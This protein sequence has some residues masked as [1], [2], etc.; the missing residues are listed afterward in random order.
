[1]SHDPLNNVNVSAQ[2]LLP[3]PHDV[4]SA[5]P[6]NERAKRVVLDGRDTVRRILD[7]SDR[8][9]FVVVGPCSIHDIK[10]AHEYAE[11]LKVLAAELSDSLF[12][13]MRVY[14]EKPRTTVGWKGRRGSEAA[15]SSAMI[16]R[17]DDNISSMDG[18]LGAAL[19][20]V[21][22]PPR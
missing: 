22:S 5:L 13:V 2:E 20:I 15:S 1:M 9:L 12:L 16:C 10:A 19:F 7:R 14:F 4:I 8:R 17:M 18:S 3:T 6:L 11:R 21:S